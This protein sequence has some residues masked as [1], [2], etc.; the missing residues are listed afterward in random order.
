MKY[1][2]KWNLKR[3]RISFLF[4][5][6][7][8]S[9]KGKGNILFAQGTHYITAPSGGGKTMLVNYIIRTITE[10]LGGFFWVNMDEF[11]SKITKTFDMTRLF[12]S[13]QQKYRLPTKDDYK[14]FS[15]GI[16]YDEFNASYNRRMNRTT[17]Y[18]E[19]FVPLIKSVV[20]HRHQG[21]QRIYILGQ[22]KQDTQLQEIL[23]YKHLV[24]ASKGY[25]YWYYRER[26]KLVSVPKKLTVISYVKIGEDSSGNATYKEISKQKIK[27]SIEI[28]ETYNTHA[29]ADMFKDLPEYTDKIKH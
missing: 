7:S 21:H 13:G 4:K 19:T 20:T 14:R 24:F 25:R 26:D 16:V 23:Q 11:D 12:E 5:I 28:L 1:L 2:N 6:L 29:F 18:N 15:Q 22:M 17:E 9:L 10:R 3:S 27:V 8:R